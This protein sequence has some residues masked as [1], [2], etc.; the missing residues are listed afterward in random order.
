MSDSRISVSINSTKHHPHMIGYTFIRPTR[1]DLS[2]LY[3][4]PT[5]N[6][7]RLAFMGIQQPRLFI[8]FKKIIMALPES[9]VFTFTN[10]PEAVLRHPANQI[11]W[12][13]L[14]V[15]HLQ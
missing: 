8:D 14:A 4:T 2:L 3:P 1:C 5:S 7:Q 13:G 11:L 6:C 9:I 10:N 15:R 12:Q